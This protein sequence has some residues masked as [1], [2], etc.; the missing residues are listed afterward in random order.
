MQLINKTILITG[1]TSGIGLELVNQL[2]ASGNEIIVLAR[3]QHKLDELAKQCG[4]M[5]HTYRCD[6]SQRQQV[7]QTMDTVITQH[8]DISVLINNAAVQYTPT[9][10]SSDFDFDSI[11]HEVTINFTAPLWITSLLLESTLLRQK[12]PVIVNVSSGLAIYPKT[13][14]AIYCATKAALHSF[15]QSLRYQLE[16]TPAR[17]VEAILPLVDTPMTQGRGN[18]KA[19]AADIAL[20]IIQAIE[21][22]RDEIY[23]GKARILPLMQRLAPGIIKDILKRS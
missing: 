20:Q 11:A 7:E 5:V 23:L 16:K 1:G 9:F 19:S 18:G 22:G 21:A 15:S 14:S 17:V 3:C 2:H 12:E 8:R 6:L 13:T 10:L 4:A